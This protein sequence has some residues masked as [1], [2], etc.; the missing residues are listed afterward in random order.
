MPKP[1]GPFL[2]LKK[3]RWTSWLCGYNINKSS[4]SEHGKKKEIE[5]HV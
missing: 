5:K 2:H 1:Q 3:N 4:F